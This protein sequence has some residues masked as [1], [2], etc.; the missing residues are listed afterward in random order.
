MKITGIYGGQFFD[1]LA[2]TLLPCDL[3][4]HDGILVEAGPHL[5]R[6]DAA[7]RILA[8]G[9]WFSPGWVDAHVHLFHAPGHLGLPAVPHCL[10]NGVTYAIDAGSAGA[11]D[12]A[13]FHQHILSALPLR[14]KAFLHCALPGAL[15][16]EPGELSSL[17]AL[18]KDA[19]T[20]VSTAFS[21]EILGGK[22]RLNPGVCPQHPEQ[23]LDE[24][25]EM[26]GQL[27]LPLEVHPN[28]APIPTTVLLNALRPGDIYTH[29]FHDSSIGIL[30]THG[31]IKDSVWQAQHRGI[32]FD[33]AHGGSSLSF[34][35]MQAALAQGFLPDFI[36]SDLHNGSYPTPVSSLAEVMSKFLAFGLSPAQILHR[37]TLGPAKA[38][39]L[40]DKRLV[41]QKGEMTA[42]TF[43]RFAEGAVSFTDGLGHY[44]T[45]LSR[46][47]PVFTLLDGFWYARE[48]LQTY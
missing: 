42:L 33:T 11:A 22:L 5:S 14:H 37:V 35:V 25:L 38:L 3:L 36:S 7:I 1:P 45:G 8:E 10:M 23:A 6:Q 34:P 17:A 4:L 15:P 31:Q 16:T 46:F 18:D 28:F 43:F 39:D 47:V 24:A 20:A 9:L 12:F 32:L 44:K 19:F 40:K 30:N 27:G 41:L 2:E 26:T 21:D 48:P 29:T 13:H